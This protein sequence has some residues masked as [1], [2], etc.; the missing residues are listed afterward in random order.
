[1][2]GKIVSVTIPR[3]PENYNIRIGVDILDD[4]GGWIKRCPG[5]KPRRVA[6]ISNLK[7]FDLYG[8]KVRKSIADAGFES[9]LHLIGDGEKYKNLRTLEKALS[10]LSESKMARTDAIV[11]LGGGVVGDL[12]GFAASVYLRGIPFLQ[13]PTTLLSMIDSSVG[14]KTGVNSAFGKNLI[15]SFYQPAGV[16]IDVT[17]L[18]TLQSRELTAGFCEAVKQAALSGKS[19]F[20]ET[21]DFL[22]QTDRD[23]VRVKNSHEI[24]RKYLTGLVDLIASQI[25]FKAGIV[26]GDEYESAAKNGRNSRKILNFGHTFGHALEKVTSYRRFKHGEAVG[27]GIVFAAT[28][29]NKLELL[30]Q[31]EVKLLND[32]VRLAGRLPALS[33][34]APGDIAKAFAYDKKQI[35]ESLQWVLLKGI[36]KPVIVPDT[37]IPRS[38]VTETLREILRK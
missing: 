27:H 33:G 32:V 4:C 7:V 28:L 3:R 18:G 19:L 10:F 23:P 29:S 5:A 21:K 35:N 1:M 37:N 16:L 6:V 25:S 2:P 31:N 15:G 38:V 24:K 22:S 20:N 36:G 12:A 13:I 8:E 11:A 14:G 9:A 26:E 30:G 34:I 17:T